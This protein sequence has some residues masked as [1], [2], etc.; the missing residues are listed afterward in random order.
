[1]AFSAL[2]AGAAWQHRG[3]RLGCEVAWF[4]PDGRGY[5]VEGCTTAVED[6][7]GWVVSYAIRLDEH[8]ATRSAQVTGRSAA[9]LRQV[10]LEA[11]GRG[12]WRVDGEAAD[13]L[14]GCLDVDLESSAL[15]NM[16]PVHR[17]SLDVGDRAPAPAAYARA[18][19]LR[20]ERLGQ[21]YARGR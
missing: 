5:R 4:R 7:Q 20:V 12:R 21:E 18:L 19:D 2:P 10:R 11:D 3:A 14:D 6:G 1:M 17:L 9:G 16:L 8:W 13:H 15:T